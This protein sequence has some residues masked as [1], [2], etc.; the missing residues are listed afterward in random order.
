MGGDRDNR[1]SVLIKIISQNATVAIFRLRRNTA[2]ILF[3]FTAKTQWHKGCTK[4]FV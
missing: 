4:S 2:V 1:D 3:L